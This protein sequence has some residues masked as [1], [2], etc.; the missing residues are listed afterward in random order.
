[1]SI[2]MRMVN[3]LWCSHAGKYYIEDKLSE[4]E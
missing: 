4:L 2:D 1:M 3:Q